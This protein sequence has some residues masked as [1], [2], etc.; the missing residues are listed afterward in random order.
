[1][2]SVGTHMQFGGRIFYPLSFQTA[3]E[4][5][6]SP[7][8][9]RKPLSLLRHSLKCCFRPQW[10]QWNDS[11]WLSQPLD[12]ALIRHS[13]P[14]G[15]LGKSY[16]V[17]RGELIHD[18]LTHCCGVW[19]HTEAITSHPEPSLLQQSSRHSLAVFSHNHLSQAR[20]AGRNKPESTSGW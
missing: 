15:A 14:C 2:I 1:M 4:I 9:A 7:F 5:S 12:E 6:D 18:A 16:C 19:A 20:Q 3:S 10:N 11:K 8:P 13:G 17:E